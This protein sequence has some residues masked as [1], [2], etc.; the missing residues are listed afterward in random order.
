M[1]VFAAA[2]SKSPV[3]ASTWAAISSTGRTCVDSTPVVFWAVTLVTAVV[4]KAPPASMVFTS[5]WI[6]APPPESLPAMESTTGGETGA[7][8]RLMVE[9]TTGWYKVVVTPPGGIAS[10]RLPP[11]TPHRATAPYPL[12]RP[13]LLADRRRRY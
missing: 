8:L 6:P 5:A 9:A 3:T 1:P 12:R 4:A 7:G 11:P 13:S 2:T 10:D